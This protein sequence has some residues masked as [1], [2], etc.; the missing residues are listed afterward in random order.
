MR[1]VRGCSSVV[2]HQLPKL[3]VRVR[4]PSPAPTKPSGAHGIAPFLVSSSGW[5]I[6]NSFAGC[7]TKSVHG[8][9]A[10]SC[11][12]HLIRNIDYG[13]PSYWTGSQRRG[14][15]CPTRPFP[16]PRSRT[17]SLCS[18]IFLESWRNSALE[19]PPP[20]GH[21]MARG[22]GFSLESVELPKFPGGLS[23]ST[24][25][26][27]GIEVPPGGLTPTARMTNQVTSFLR[28]RSRPRRSSRSVRRV[29]ERVR[30]VN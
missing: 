21:S 19:C 4:F 3:T 23:N 30:N 1:G 9:A 25:E 24:E 20:T 15:S 18:V 14:T 22:G 28:T 26:T 7:S 5:A 2:E 17:W 16:E 29:K 27:V 8:H 10:A 13:G 6:P 11:L 12:R